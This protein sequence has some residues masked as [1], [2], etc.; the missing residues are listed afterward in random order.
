MAFDIGLIVPAGDPDPADL[1]DTKVMARTVLAG[2][3]GDLGDVAVSRAW[4][5]AGA[6]YL[7]D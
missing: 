1:G 2:R 5:R 6:A 3:L 7:H 4:L